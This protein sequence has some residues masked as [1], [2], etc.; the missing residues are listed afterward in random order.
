MI[1]LVAVIWCLAAF[2]RTTDW[3]TS[4]RQEAA[5]AA[6]Y[7]RLANAQKTAAAKVESWAKWKLAQC[8]A[9]GQVL[10][11]DATGDP[12]CTMQSPAQP[13]PMPDQKAVGMGGK[14]EVPAK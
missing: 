7:H 12:A 6:Q 8:K 1:T 11:L 2:I 9:K 4:A 10:M 14:V 5:D 3:D 13:Q